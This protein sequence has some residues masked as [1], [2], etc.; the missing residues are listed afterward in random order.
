MTNEE[1]APAHT[2]ETQQ[3]LANETP[4]SE[5][6]WLDINY[7][8]T[9]YVQRSLGLQQDPRL[10]NAQGAVLILPEIGQHADWPGS[11][12]HLRT[13]LPDSGWYSLSISLP[14]K[15]VSKPP[16]RSLPEKQQDELIL[17]DTL[18][19][20]LA[21]PPVRKEADSTGEETEQ[22]EPSPET[23]GNEESVDIN[24]SERNES[25][26]PIPPLPEQAIAHIKA[27]MDHLTANGYRNII[28]IA[29]GQSA[30][31]ALQYLKPLAASF[32]DRGFALILIDAQ[33]QA[34]FDKNI[35]EALGKDFQAPIMDII[36][37]T[38]DPE[39]TNEKMRLKMA[40]AANISRYEQVKLAAL[41]TKTLVKRIDSWL[42]VQAP[43]MA[44]TKVSGP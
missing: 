27:A 19:S 33:L 23:T 20:A 15:E 28:L 39:R 17:N 29:L 18:R 8:D 32:K 4:A 44:A 1:N 6:V 30:E 36:R 22:N 40:R 43:G 41:D 14:Q 3:I 5:H 25:D 11:V 10:P 2:P 16:T 31:H 42:R 35:S 34:P 37:T 24:L 9:S 26:A 21:A 38:R 13:T 7:P 12:R